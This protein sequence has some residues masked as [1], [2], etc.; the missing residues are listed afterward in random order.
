MEKFEK[1][2]YPFRALDGRYYASMDDVERANKTYWDYKNPKIINKMDEMFNAPLTQKDL[3]RIAAS[4]TY[5][6]LIALIEERF[7][8]STQIKRDNPKTTKR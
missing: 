7:A 1:K 5:L 4:P 8:I 6:E 2:D 3:E